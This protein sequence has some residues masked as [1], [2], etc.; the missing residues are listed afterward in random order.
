MTDE[1][2]EIE[3]I[4][5][6]LLRQ[7]SSSQRRTLMRRMARD[8]A[9]S[10]RARI[11]AQR[12]PSGAAFEPRKKKAEPIRGRSAVA[13][14]YPSGGS[15]TARRVTMKSYVIEHRMMTGFDIETGAI[16][17]FMVDK[18]IKWLPVEA[19]HRNAAGG[20]MLRRRGSL[21][22]KAMFKKLASARNLRSGADDQGFWVGFSGR[23]AE[24]A[25]I[26]HEGLRDRP[27]LKAR[28]MRYPR[29]ELL[30]VTEA[31]RADM[32]HV[33]YAHL[34]EAVD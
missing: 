4:A 33:L 21:R 17:S 5:G 18:V 28:A 3:A 23:A 8:L 24:V 11:A 20:G 31:E 19:E 30:G 25:R 15:G 12:D 6:G 32:L 34:A 1:L 10:Q 2:T 29:R 7:L 16:R 26:H 9:L 13:F 22:R 14:L 27:S